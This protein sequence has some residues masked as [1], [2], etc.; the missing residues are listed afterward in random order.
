VS[1]RHPEIVI[2][3]EGA[4]KV[5]GVDQAQVNPF[6]SGITINSRESKTRA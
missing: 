2:P 1:G 5:S 6:N 4:K 3:K